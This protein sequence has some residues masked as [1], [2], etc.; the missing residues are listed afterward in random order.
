MGLKHDIKLRKIPHKIASDMIIKNHYS[1][2]MPISTILNIGIYY[3]ERLVGTIIY[4]QGN[5]T[6]YH[7]LIKGSKPQKNMEL[8]RLWTEDDLPS[9]LISRAISIKKIKHNNPLLDFII[10]FADEG[11]ATHTGIIYQASN[12][13]YTGTS[14][15]TE[16][17]YYLNGKKYHSRGVG[18]TFGVSKLSELQKLFKSVRLVKRKNRKHRYIFPLKPEIREE[19]EKIR[20]PYPKIQADIV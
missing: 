18:A 4:N 19:V 9:G 11:Y 14:E 10:S 20:K 2:R 8:I 6:C 17:D 3:K 5:S 16:I 12:F 15:G 1:H 7:N 13:I